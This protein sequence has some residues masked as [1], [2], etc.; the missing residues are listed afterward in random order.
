MARDLSKVLII[1]LEASCWR[2]DEEKPAGQINEIIEFG[3]VLLDVKTKQ[4]LKSKSILV[5]PQFSTISEF[6]TELTTL[7]QDL[8]DNEGVSFIQALEIL[9]SEFKPRDIA[10]ISYG[11]YDRNQMTKNC[12]LYNI[13]N[14]LNQTHINIKNIFALRNNLKKEVGMEPA[15]KI[16]GEPL[17]GQHHRGLDDALNI[18]KIVIKTL[19]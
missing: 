8:L 10:W 15:L 12:E 16:L 17:T 5:K 1:D 18:C 14:P 9:K 11:D 19:F 3:C 4:I 13:K 6:C 2:S 7:T